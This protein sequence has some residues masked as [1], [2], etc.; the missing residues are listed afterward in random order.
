[1]T[2]MIFLF[3]AFLMPKYIP[4]KTQKNKLLKINTLTEYGKNK[5]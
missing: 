4:K 2:R 5:A 3:Y 1:M